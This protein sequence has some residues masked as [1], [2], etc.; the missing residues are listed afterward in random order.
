MNEP[1]L[2]TIPEVASA[3]RINKSYLYALLSAGALRSVRLG[4]RR[5]ITRE[6]LQRFIADREG[7]AT[8]E[9]AP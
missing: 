7:D 2:M 3:L 9:L 4:R 6:A 1:V 8:S 5:L